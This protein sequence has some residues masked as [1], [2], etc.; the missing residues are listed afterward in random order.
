LCEALRIDEE[1]ALF[2]GGI[3][4]EGRPVPKDVIK[5]L[6]AVRG[7]RGSDSV[8]CARLF[9]ERSKSALQCG[10]IDQAL[11][12]SESALR[13]CLENEPSSEA[14]SYAKL[15][16]ALAL[17]AVA[18]EESALEALGLLHDILEES[19]P[20]SPNATSLALLARRRLRATILCSSKHVR[21]KTDGGSVLYHTST[22][23]SETYRLQIRQAPAAGSRVLLGVPFALAVAIT[24]EFGLYRHNDL[25]SFF[26]PHITRPYEPLRLRITLSE[27]TKVG[28]YDE[29]MQS[30]DLVDG[31][32]EFTLV[33][34]EKQ[35]DSGQPD[36]AKQDEWIRL[37]VEVEQD[38]SASRRI[39]DVSTVPLTIHW[40]GSR[41]STASESPLVPLL[42]SLGVSSCRIL[43]L[44][45]NHSQVEVLLAESASFL[46]IAG[47]VW[48]A[49]FALIE[50][51]T[52]FLRAPERFPFSPNG[53]IPTLI[54]E[55]G[56]GTGA[57]SLALA[58]AL[59]KLQ[60]KIIA[61]D[62]DAVV[63]LL[64][65]NIALNKGLFTGAESNQTN[66]PSAVSLPWGTPLEELSV[67]FRDA[68]SKEMIVIMADVVYDPDLYSILVSTL[69]DLLSLPQCC[70]AIMAYQK[71]HP[72]DH[73]F[74]SLLANNSIRCK[75]Y[76]QPNSNEGCTSRSASIMFLSHTN[77]RNLE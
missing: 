34:V 70:G 63:P 24:N 74:F 54:V 41:P 45:G 30:A 62:L 48:D 37:V 50:F 11:A 12:D 46:G 47:K 27:E 61:T 76:A 21:V 39:L 57:T 8:R 4:E 53:E 6:N 26:A 2:V 1:I 68:D 64:R 58:V 71:R 15:A 42:Q 51:F 72:D 69:S 25:P 60:P 14:R 40:P 77:K 10:N 17:E 75:P 23:R 49:S 44:H 43:R 56:A 16:K 38:R 31:R 36:A 28:F 20:I 29:S 67:P 7:E 66:E 52:A 65:L 19:G 73:Q 22:N 3:Y 5:W 32:A 9:A 33:L 59:Q 35:R 55:L 13:C 18:D